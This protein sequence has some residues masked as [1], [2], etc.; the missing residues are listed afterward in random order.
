MNTKQT[1]EGWWIIDGDTHV[2]KWVE[3]TGKLD[4]DEF[5][6]PLCVL[7][8]PVGG[9]VIDA[10]ALYGDHSIAYA[11]KV[12]SQGTV[13]AIESNPVAFSCLQRNAEKFESPVLLINACLGTEHGGKARHC[14]QEGNIGMST[15]QVTEEDKKGVEIPTIS[16]DG[17]MRDANLRRVDFLK[18][19]VEGWEHRVLLGGRAMLKLLRPKML[20]EINSFALS[21]QGS[22]DRDIYDLLLELQYSWQIVQPECTGSSP[23]FDILCWGN[24]VISPETKLIT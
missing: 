13:I 1:K 6:I 18:L 2:G 10:G 23:Q 21:Q 4:H 7:N 11:R 16:L 20:I 3:D 19:D 12:G 9:V 24:Q 14:I 17:L 5:T 22:T 8:M 15:C